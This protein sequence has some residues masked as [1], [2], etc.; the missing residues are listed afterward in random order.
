MNRPA[1]RQDLWLFV[2]QQF[3]LRLPWR[4]FTAGHSSPFDF[5]A[6]AFW[7][8]ADNVAAWANRSGGKTL[9]ASVLAALQFCPWEGYRQRKARV[10]SGSEYQASNLYNYWAQWCSSP[11]LASISRGD[12]GKHLTRLAIGDMEILSAS[13]KRVRGG[14]VQDL[15]RD[16]EDEIEPDVASAAVGML[17][18]MDGLPARIIVTSTWHRAN[19]PMGRL[20]QNAGEK[21]YRLHK[22]N[23][24]ESIA[25][26]EP[27][28][29]EYGRGCLTCRLG[30]YCLAKGREQKPGA[31]IGIAAEC[32]GIFA[33]DD[34]I[35]QAL[36]WSVEQFAAEA[37]C[38]RPSLQGLVYPQF[39][40]AIHVRDLDF[41]ANLPTYRSID[42]GINGFVCLWFQE[43]KD[44][45]IYV[46][47][48]YHATDATT[49]KC[50]LD[51]SRD[52][53]EW[54]VV[55]TYCDP[56]GRQRSDQTGRSNIEVLRSIGVPCQY[57]TDPWATTV[58]NG[59]SLIRGAL[60]P[61][62]GLPRLFIAS[63]CKGLI[64]AF[65]AYALRQVNDQWVDEPK[66]PQP[67]E[68]WMDALRYYFVNRR[69]PAAASSKTWSITG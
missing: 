55:G 10:L 25:R 61:A 36:E 57:R 54:P 51:I 48:E 28:R 16:E 60:R 13:Q 26:C 46:V 42:W 29:H 45:T 32:D 40:R 50:G 17:A 23:I 35:K 21:G 20:V 58:A 22:W 59:I 12:L 33:I 41:D 30:K 9:S 67:A 3:G 2:W 69:A 49:Y 43:G 37:E 38:K 34:A 62:I 7:N 8:P 5:V 15:F 19:G 63:S 64:K 4:K 68:H 53:K 27:E 6:D 56:A 52:D 1:T 44:G 24:W 31:T 39:D 14:K 18:S 11:V 47:D 65:E 66:D